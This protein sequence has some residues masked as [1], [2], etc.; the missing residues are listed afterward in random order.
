MK[1]LKP[2]LTNAIVAGIYTGEFRGHNKIRDKKLAKKFYVT[3]ERRIFVDTMLDRLENL[4]NTYGKKFVTT[5]FLRRLVYNLN[6]KANINLK[7]YQEWNDFF[8]RCITEINCIKGQNMFLPQG[9]AD[10]EHWYLN[11]K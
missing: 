7:D 4:V 1:R 8:T 5:Q 6:T 3:G 10:F 2:R 11:I 9:D